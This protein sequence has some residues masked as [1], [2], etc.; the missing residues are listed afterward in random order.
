MTPT[1]DCVLML[2]SNP[3]AHIADILVQY[4]VADDFHRITQTFDK[5]DKNTPNYTA[6]RQ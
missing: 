3:E 6:E 1:N 2:L 4:D 5:D